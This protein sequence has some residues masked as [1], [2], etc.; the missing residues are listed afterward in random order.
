MRKEPDLFEPKDQ[1]DWRK[2]LML[3]HKKEDAVWLVFYKKASMAH[4]LSWSDAVDE[5]LCFGWIDSTKKTMDDVRYK[6]YF[7]RR[8]PKSNWS[9]IN[10]QKVDKLIKSKRM[11]KAGLESIEIA[12]ENGSWTLL[13]DV[14]ALIVP[15]DLED[16]LASYK[17]ARD[18]FDGLSASAKKALL[19]WVISAKRQE[20]REKRI[21]EIAEN[22]AKQQ[23][24]K[25]F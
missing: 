4:N 17:T 24:P 8:K 3:N 11:T 22:A 23:K 21:A 25:Q 16:A 13:D 15:I 19:Y 9:K 5:A 10:K 14:E 6:Q 1:S 20:T 7:S 2:W 18:Y 12:K